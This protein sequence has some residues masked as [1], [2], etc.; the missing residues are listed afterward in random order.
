M[1]LQL[2]LLLNGYRKSLINRCCCS[3]LSHFSELDNW[4]AIW[5][6]LVRLQTISNHNGY[7]RY[8]FL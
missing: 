4:M 6:G 3:Y 5:Q 8:I 7:F 1:S 2:L